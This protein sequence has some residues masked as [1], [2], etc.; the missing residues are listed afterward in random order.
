MIRE[1]L[2]Q[3][4]E[5]AIYENWSREVLGDLDIKIEAEDGPA[6]GDYSTN[7]VFEASQRVGWQVI[8]FAHELVRH[9]NAAKLSELDRIET[10]GPLQGFI[11]FYLSHD[12]LQKQVGLIVA[13]EDY[14]MGD[15]MK[16]KTVMVEFTDPNPFKLFHI[17]HMMSNAI[18]E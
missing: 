12:F 15:G 18:G 8:T 9:L 13:D 7:I 5:E 16:N 14:G 17:G 1:K 11:N 10:A 6:F 2:R 4:V 3:F